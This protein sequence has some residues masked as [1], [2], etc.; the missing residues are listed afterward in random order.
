MSDSQAIEA[1]VHAYL[2]LSSGADLGAKR[3][4]WD[5]DEPFPLLAPEELPQALIGWAA[6]DR[7]WS[8]TGA[9]L[10]GL[11]TELL[12]IHAR[13]LT[14]DW[15]TAIYAQR[16]RASIPSAAALLPRPIASTVRVMMGLRQRAS[17]W[18]ICSIVEGH[19]DG[20]EYFR[21]HYRSR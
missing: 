3:A 17:G 15:A 7:Y 11:H 5:A 19:V 4:F 2:A 20:V 10:D 12:S 16:W 14:Q 1:L 6:I 21:A 13:R 18:R 9:L 8:E